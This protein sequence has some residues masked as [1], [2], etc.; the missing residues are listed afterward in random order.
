MKKPL[1]FIRFRFLFTLVCLLIF[2]NAIGQEC[3]WSKQIK[4]GEEESCSA[5]VTDPAGN[6]YAAGVFNS[7]FLYFET[8][9]FSTG[10]YNNIFLVKYDASGNELWA[11][12]FLGGGAATSIKY[13]SYDNSILISGLFW[14]QLNLGDTIIHGDEDYDAFV[15][16]TD[17]NGNT[18]WC[19]SGGGIGCDWGYDVTFDDDGNIYFSGECPYTATFGSQQ[20]DGGG[21]LAKYSAAGELIWVKKKFRNMK[22]FYDQECEAKPKNIQCIGDTLMVYGDTGNDTIVIDTFQFI[23]P[24]IV[25]STASFIGYFNKD[26]NLIKMNFFGF[27]YSSCASS[28]DIPSTQLMYSGGSFMKDCIFNGDTFHSSQNG[29][30]YII[31]HT[32]DGGIEWV[33]HTTSPGYNYP[34]SISVDPSG[35]VYLAGVF[36]DTTIFGNDT[37]VS[38]ANQD[39]YV[40]HYSADGEV[41]GVRQFTDGNMITST[42]DNE[43]NLI[44]VGTFQ[45]TSTIGPNT[46]TSMG[47]TDVFVAK[48]SPIT[49]T[50]ESPAGPSN[51]LLIYANP[52]TGKC[53]ITIPDE[54]KHEKEL[55]LYIYDSQGRLVQ[56]AAIQEAEGTYRLNIRAQAA[57]IYQAVLSNGTKR[58]SGK[59]VFAKND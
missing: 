14:G 39:K 36:S 5:V 18:I 31:K 7:T 8:D 53:N 50:K 6:I 44:I 55:T 19:R 35:G 24:D 58:Y 23:F 37:L 28:M 40:A 51:K 46:F 48:C 34:K 13:N 42:L 32:P 1:K 43:G 27:P 52:T 33:R 57:G 21:F 59:I 20:I 56:Q 41:L 45:N 38:V 16:K 49:S 10:A 26:G 3:F 11:K 25:A 12:H 9:T 47:A 22:V 2:H 17:L 4:G 29:D 30:A 54:F 15:L